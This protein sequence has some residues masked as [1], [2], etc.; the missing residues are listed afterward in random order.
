MN[1]AGEAL[2][3][4]ATASVFF[5]NGIV[6]MLEACF[7]F[8]VFDSLTKYLIGSFTTGEIVFVRF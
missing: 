2:P 3:S 6:I 8:A 1:R 7:F 4:G 5:D